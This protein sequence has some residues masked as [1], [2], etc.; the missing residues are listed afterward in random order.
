MVVD[1]WSEPYDIALWFRAAERIDVPAGGTVPGPLNLV[2]L[3]EPTTGVDHD[4]A[5]GWLGWWQ[6][7]TRQP[8]WPSGGTADLAAE[9]RLVS[10]SPPPQ[11][12]FHP[13]EF[14]GLAGWPALRRIVMHRWSEADRWQNQRKADGVMAMHR[15]RPSASGSPSLI[16]AEVERALGRRVPPF[17]IEFV[18]LPVRDTEIRQVAETRYLVPEAV[19]G[20]PDWTEWLRALVVRLAG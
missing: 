17:D 6:A 5:E 9:L 4:L 14:P 7:L 2:P 18:V 3:P 16:V 8:R 11:V 10:S 15:S 1:Q 19:F 13:P 12:Q 20:G